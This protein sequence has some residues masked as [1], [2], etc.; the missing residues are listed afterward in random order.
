L[1]IL[2]S[3]IKIIIAPL[4]FIFLLTTYPPLLLPIFIL[5]IKLYLPYLEDPTDFQVAIRFRVKFANGTDYRFYA[6]DPAYFPPGSE[7]VDP[8]DDAD[9]QTIAALPNATSQSS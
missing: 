3:N 9:Q 4:H 6:A 2:F 7:T 5:T 1:P 8:T